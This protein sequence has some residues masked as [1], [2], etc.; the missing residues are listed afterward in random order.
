MQLNFSKLMSLDPTK[1]GQ[2]TNS[3]GQLIEFFE[4][5]LRGDEYPVIV[6]CKE[7]QLAFASDFYDLDDMTAEHKEYEPIITDGHLSYGQN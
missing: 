7:L 1:Y 4:H 5:P 3:K 6:V 2:M